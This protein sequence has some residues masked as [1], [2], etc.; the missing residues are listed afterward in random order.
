M[1]DDEEAAKK[2]QEAED[3]MPPDEEGADGL[4]EGVEMDV[5]G[6]D[7]M[8]E[9]PEGGCLV[10]DVPDPAA[11]Q[12]SK[13]TK[14]RVRAGTGRCDRSCRV[15]LRAVPQQDFG[16]HVCNSRMSCLWCSSAALPPERH[17]TLRSCPVQ[18][19]TLSSQQQRTRRSMHRQTS[20]VLQR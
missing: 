14:R 10:A 3:E 18:V 9:T 12:L 6:V 19:R 4:P 2:L 16:Q 7:G 15:V 20:L 5:E 13:S 11:A 8:P 1:Q 17:Q